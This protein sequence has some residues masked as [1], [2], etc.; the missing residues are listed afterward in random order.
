MKSLD[1][2]LLAVLLFAQGLGVPVGSNYPKNPDNSLSVSSSA[3]GV[4]TGGIIF[5]DAGTCPTGFTQDTAFNGAYILGTVAANADVGLT[6]GSN[7]VTPTGSVSAPTLTMNS[8]TP[9]GTNAAPALTMNSY[10]PAGTNAAPALAMNSYAPAGTVSA[11]TFAGA[12]Q[13]FTTKGTSTGSAANF[14]GPNPYTPAGTVSAPS[15]TGTAATLTGSVAAPGFTGTAATLT[16]SVAAPGFTGTAAT[17][18]G[19]V[20]APA[21]TGTAA[22]IQPAYL[23]V[24]ACKAN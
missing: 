24:I 23:K 1:G 19:S 16:G 20:S 9:A 3:G 8:Y 22:T 14:T 2:V 15:F 12:A 5:I 11:P 4:P 18:T 13:T 17:L 6:G 10:T 21:F 7:S